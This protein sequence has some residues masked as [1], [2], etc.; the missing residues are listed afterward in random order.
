M[1]ATVHG[2]ITKPAI[3]VA[4]AWDP[5]VAAHHELFEQLDCQ[6]RRN[7]LS[8]LVVAIDP[9]PALVLRGRARWPV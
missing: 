7:G 1:N 3:A 5:M 4:G 8:S 6:A 9:D 2:Q